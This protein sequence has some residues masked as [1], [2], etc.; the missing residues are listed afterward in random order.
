M[1]MHIMFFAVTVSSFAMSFEETAMGFSDN[2]LKI[3]RIGYKA[4]RLVGILVETSS[5]FAIR[6]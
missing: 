5:C 6:Q 3:I 2:T 1:R 4:I